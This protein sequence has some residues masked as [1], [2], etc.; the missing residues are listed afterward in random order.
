M[1]RTIAIFLFLPTIFWSCKDFLDLKPDKKMVVPNSLEDC[2][3]L[4]NDYGIMNSVYPNIVEIAADDYYLTKNNWNALSAIDE[5]NAYIWAD[6][7]V[8]NVTQ[9]QNPFKVIYQ[10]NQI[11]EVLHGLQ[12]PSKHEALFEIVKGGAHFF[13]GFS[14]HQMIGAYTL[15]Y[16]KDKAGS[17]LGIPLRLSPDLDYS[18]ARAS[19]HESYVQ[20]IADYKE[21]V[22][23]LPLNEEARGR[24]SKA[25]AYAGLARLYLEMQ[26]YEMAFHYADSVLQINPILMDFNTLNASAAL[27]IARF[28]GEVLFAAITPNS[29][30][31]SQGAAKIDSLLY[32]SYA[33]N[34]LRKS[35]FF[36][37]NTGANAGTYAFKGS[38]NNTAAGLFVGLTTSEAYL[39]Y[40][41]A[42][43]RTG[44]IDRAFSA[45]NSL[46]DKRYQTGTFDQITGL[47]QDQLLQLIL[48]ERRKEL[49]F[50]GRRWTDLKRLNLD[51]RFA[52]RIVRFLDD[53]TF[54]LEV[55]SLK[56][57][58]LL[59][60]VAIAD[61]QLEQNW[62]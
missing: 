37:A 38:Y 54:S 20:I 26:E 44:R 40:A 48:S 8:E 36:R 52:K 50:R 34:D 61:G 41:E 43:A 56:Y 27:P 22:K 18:K 28:N 42:A 39:I 6:D 11:L 23:L 16:E 17:L 47:N 51:I 31:L 55:N 33:A 24:P 21:A 57:A 5:R 45:I 9:W 60:E 12:S 32:R 46:L 14:F 25:S 58:L 1:I 3:L 10:C 62:R 13:R 59:P 29:T 2:N 7:P 35:I 30:A 49:V 4:L 15:T 53:E 19:L